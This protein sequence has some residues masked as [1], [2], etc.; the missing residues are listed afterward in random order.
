MHKSVAL[1]TYEGRRNKWASTKRIFERMCGLGNWGD[2]VYYCVESTYADLNR[3][4]A[5]GAHLQYVSPAVSHVLVCTWDGFIVNPKRW[6]DDWLQYDMIGGPWPSENSDSCPID[7]SWA[8]VNRVGNFGFC[9]LS[10]KFLEA[11]NKIS[12]EYENELGDK[13]MCCIKYDYFVN[14]CGIRYADPVVAAAFSW[15][16]ECTEHN[17]KPQEA[18]GFHGWFEGKSEAEYHKKYIDC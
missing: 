18:F 9:L 8:K 17:G 6:T 3:F 12:G 2:A 16:W 14:Q 13:Y 11:A 5:T 1:F 15:D 7:W 10:R 4:E